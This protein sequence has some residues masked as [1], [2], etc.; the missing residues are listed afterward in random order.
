MSYQVHWHEGLFLQPHHFQQM[1]RGVFG[2]LARMRAQACPYSYGISEIEVS[3]DE[4][5]NNLL[6]FRRL[7]GVM[8]GGAE[9]SYPSN[10]NLPTLDLS[11]SSAV[12][13]D[14]V[15]ILLG[16]PLWQENRANCVVT[17][18]RHGA[19]GRFHYTI[20]EQEVR[21]ENTGTNEK[22]LAF[23]MLNARLL[24]DGDDRSDL[25][26]IPLV[27]LIASGA[28][29]AGRYRLDHDFIGPC[30]FAN[31]SSRLHNIAKD[32]AHLLEGGRT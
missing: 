10:C 5:E 26:V 24:V 1:Q 14:V 9:F 25:E 17:E 19:S 27:R 11:T 13:G 22:P 30:L 32:T 16:I 2:Q 8:P 15:T 28:D 20:H 7:G 6:R 21:D 29:R 3:E 12:R 31:A 4:L 18:D 23:R